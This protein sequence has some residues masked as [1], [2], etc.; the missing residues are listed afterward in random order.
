MFAL[1]LVVALFIANVIALPSF[2][3]QDNWNA[4][5]TIFA[6]FALLA[7][8]ATP[9]ILSGGGGIDLSVSPLAGLVAIVFIEYLIPS[10]FGRPELAIPILLALGAAVGATNGFLVTV[11]RYQPVIA[12]L[13]ALFVLTGINIKLV[14]FAVAA[15]P[16][17]TSDLRGSIGPIPGALLT[18]GAPVVVWLLLK[19]TPYY[20]TLFATAFSAGV[21]VAR[22]RIIAYA[23]GGFYAGI[24]AIAVTTLF[25]AADPYAGSQYTLIAIAA[26]VLGGTPVGGGRGGLLGSILGAVCIFLVQNL[27]SS[28]HVSSLWLQVA[29]GSLLLVGVVVGAITTAPPRVPRARQVTA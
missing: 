27:L 17:W 22:V 2:A 20:R 18:I 23:L 19:R 25:E 21:N 10:D 13:C 11:V 28:L 15:P 24:A 5:L 3:S 9:S 7:M 16:N 12:T 26:V 4:D 14:S 29:Y 8:A 6:P 1:V